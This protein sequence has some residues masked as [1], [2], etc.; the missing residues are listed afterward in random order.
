MTASDSTLRTP[1]LHKIQQL[2]GN[3]WHSK[4]LLGPC[5]RTATGS[6]SDL[7]LPVPFHVTIIRNIKATVYHVLGLAL[8][9]DC[10]PFA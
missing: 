5:C 6:C 7:M 9:V 4:E 1:D 10:D 3:A 8:N 2:I